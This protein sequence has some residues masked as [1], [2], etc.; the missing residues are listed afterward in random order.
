MESFS[1]IRRRSRSGDGQEWGCMGK[2][3]GGGEKSGSGDE[4]F[5]SGRTLELGGVYSV[6]R[7][8]VRKH[9]RG[10]GQRIINWGWAYSEKSKT[11][12]SSVLLLSSRQ[13]YLHPSH[14]DAHLR[15]GMPSRLCPFLRQ[16][17]APLAWRVLGSSPTTRI[18]LPYLVAGLPDAKRDTP[19]DRYLVSCISLALLIT[20]HLLG[21]VLV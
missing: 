18:P 17:R 12:E 6:C 4:T 20:A 5:K 1:S 8:M 10:D 15:S 7:G 14:G 2:R 19:E 21:L 13:W 11:Y 16:C 3:R 9:G